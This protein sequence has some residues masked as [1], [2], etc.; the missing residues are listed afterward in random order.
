MLPGS[1]STETSV[2]SRATADD[3]HP[4]EIGHTEREQG[5]P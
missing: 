2:A 5:L 3:I 4:V 1:S